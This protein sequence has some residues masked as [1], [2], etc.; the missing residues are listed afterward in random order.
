MTANAIKDILVARGLTLCVAESL[1][2]GALAAEIV[3]V[4][5]VSGCFL[6]GVVAYQDEIKQEFL[7]VSEETLKRL[8]AV[9][10]KCAA[11]MARGAR[12]AFHADYALATTGY[13]GPQGDPPGRVYIALACP[14]GERVWR[15]T[16]RGA[17]DAVRGITV[18]MALYL[19][20]K[21][22]CTHGEE[23]IDQEHDGHPGNQSRK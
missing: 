2:G 1:T 13:G 4:P 12:R 9:S 21:E 15:F 11:E 19:L 8:T 6:G 7:H 5:G 10:G 14:A 20:E 18:Q 22:L 3:R 23:G 17:R 16:F